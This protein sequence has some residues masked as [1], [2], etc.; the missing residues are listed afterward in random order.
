MKFP[1]VFWWIIGK[2]PRDCQAFW[3]ALISSVQEWKRNFVTLC[4]CWFSQ[5][6]VISDG[7]KTQRGHT[8]MP[9]YEYCNYNSFPIFRTA[10]N[11]FLCESPKSK[12]LFLSVCSCLKA[13]S[14]WIS[15]KVM[16]LVWRLPF[17]FRCESSVDFNRI[18]SWE[19]GEAAGMLLSC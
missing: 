5:E 13:L 19:G 14:W 4:L 3:L 15:A 2:I 6:L 11:K 7:M 9:H 17:D 1:A 16:L 8:P 18:S 10:S 12:S